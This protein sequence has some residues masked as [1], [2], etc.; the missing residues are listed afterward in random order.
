[1]MWKRIINKNIP[2]QRWCLEYEIF[3]HKHDMNNK[4]KDNIMGCVSVLKRNLV[5]NNNPDIYR[6]NAVISKITDLMDLLNILRQMENS[7][8]QEKTLNYNKSIMLSDPVT[9][10]LYNWIWKASRRENI[11]VKELM[12]KII[13]RTERVMNSD[14]PNVYLNR[15]MKPFVTEYESL[16]DVLLVISSH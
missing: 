10:D 2:I 4:P 15:V 3:K 11:T 13:T 8:V 1:M 12:I 16:L 7:L 5:Y 14:L 9:V 6:E